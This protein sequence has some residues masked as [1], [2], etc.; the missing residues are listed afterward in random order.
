MTTSPTPPIAKCGPLCAPAYDLH[1]HGTS[2]LHDKIRPSG[3]RVLITADTY[4]SD[5]GDIAKGDHTV[6]CLVRREIEGAS[7]P[8]RKFT[9]SVVIPADKW[10]ASIRTVLDNLIRTGTRTADAYDVFNTWHGPSAETD[11]S[12]GWLPPHGNGVRVILSDGDTF[13]HGLA[14]R[15]NPNVAAEPLVD[16]IWK[17]WYYQTRD[18][19]DKF[20][21]VAW[22]ELEQLR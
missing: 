6:R 10:A 22:K 4:A 19:L 21:V 5:R 7:P 15:V 17:L 8:N 3:A 14:T 2:V 20:H 18:D 1:I 16:G 12:G 9:V 11:E 13:T